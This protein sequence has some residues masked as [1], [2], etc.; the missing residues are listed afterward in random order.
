M[1]KSCNVNKHPQEKKNSVKFFWTWI[2]SYVSGSPIKG[3][4]DMP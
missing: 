3:R 2:P 4:V 1:E